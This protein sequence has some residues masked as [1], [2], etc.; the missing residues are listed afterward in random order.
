M[1]KICPKCE[2]R[3]S[4]SDFFRNS[5]KK[6]GLQAICKKCVGQNS[7][8][9]YDKNKD[10]LKLSIEK[11]RLKRAKEN[12]EYVLK[13]LKSNPCVDCGEKDPLVLD[14]DHVRGTKKMNVAAM[15]QRGNSVQAIEDEIKKCDVRCSNCHRRKTAK[16][17]GWFKVTST[18]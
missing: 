4:L 16:H 5:S 1:T 13:H 11:S 10:S 15:I 17:Q 14:F 6:D 9:Y 7:S 2:I 18:L 3:K 12:K 8:S